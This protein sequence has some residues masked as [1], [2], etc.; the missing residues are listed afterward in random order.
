MIETYRRLKSERSAGEVDDSGFTLIELLIVI[1]VLGILAAIVVFALGS[2]TG[3]SVVAACNADAKTIDVG[4]QAFVTEN[5]TTTPANNAA[6]QADLLAPA[7]APAFA[8]EV[9]MPFL[10]SWPQS[11]GNPPVWITTAPYKISVAGTAEVA[12]GALTGTN[13]GTITPPTPALGDVIVTIP[14]ALIG[15]AANDVDGTY[16]ATSQPS[17]ACTNA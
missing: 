7:T 2:V 10:Q 5:P 13:G 3:K 9:G 12:A 8:S 16:D 17:T 4:A 1:V 15:N 14:G 11:N 6:W